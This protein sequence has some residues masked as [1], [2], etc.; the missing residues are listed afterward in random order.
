MVLLLSAV[1]LLVFCQCNRQQHKYGA[2]AVPAIL[3]QSM[4]LCKHS[5]CQQALLG[6]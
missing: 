2:A 1:L 5:P 4:L 3:L 6:A